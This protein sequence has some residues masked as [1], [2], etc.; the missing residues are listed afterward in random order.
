M[1]SPISI[2]WRDLRGN[3]QQHVPRADV[4]GRCLVKFKQMLEQMKM[5]IVN[6]D[7]QS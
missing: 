7:L 1:L 6:G 2:S 4:C 5:E 3:L